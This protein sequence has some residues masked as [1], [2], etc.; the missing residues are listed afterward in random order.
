MISNKPYAWNFTKHGK[1]VE[2]I[3]SIEIDKVASFNSV[4]LSTP[5]DF[6]II[7]RKHS[8]WFYSPTWN[9]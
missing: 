7:F 4:M 5:N 8:L 2:E 9:S 3:I 1:V 6:V